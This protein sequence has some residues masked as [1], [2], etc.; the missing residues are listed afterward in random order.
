VQNNHAPTV[1]DI[2]DKTFTTGVMFNSE[3]YH[4]F[5]DDGKLTYTITL[6][7]GSPIPETLAMTKH[8]LLV[9]TISEDISL[10][11]TATDESGSSVSTTLQLN[12]NNAPTVSDIPTINA[13]IDKM[14]MYE[15]NNYFTDD[16][17]LDITATLT[18]DKPL[19]DWVQIH[20][21]SKGHVVLIGTMPKGMQTISVLITGTDTHGIS[22]SVPVDIIPNYAPTT[23]GISDRVVA[24]GNSFISELSE[25]FYDLDGDTMTFTSDNLPDDVF[26]DKKSGAITGI[27]HNNTKDPLVHIIPI[28]AID[29]HGASITT[30]MNIIVKPTP[31][32]PILE[33]EPEP[34]QSPVKSHD[35]LHLE[36]IAGETL[37]FDFNSQIEDP[38][39]DALTFSYYVANSSKNPDWL[40]IDPSTGVLT[41]EVPTTV[42]GFTLNIYVVANDGNGGETRM[43]TEVIGLEG[44][45]APEGS[46]YDITFREGQIFTYDVG[47]QVKD[48][49]G[50]ALTYALI[51]NYGKGLVDDIQGLELADLQNL[52]QNL[53]DWL[54][55]SSDSGILTADF[56][57]YENDKTE[58]YIPFTFTD[59][60]ESLDFS[61]YAWDDVGAG[62]FID[63][64]NVSIY[65]SAVLGDTGIVL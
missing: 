20:T 28:T 30:T 37:A 29:E 48:I 47:S 11:I 51:P 52:I 13:T 39:G 4:Y 49:D 38:D 53:P 22:A 12:S 17:V 40:T 45:Q 43:L 42:H 24:S 44:N 7:N 35:K 26:L 34:N 23:E 57:D 5:N 46:I 18:N 63:N 59:G 62:G 55:F 58:S 41:G 6:A 31:V 9:G 64:F 19:P 16:G 10:I 61:L 60:A 1:S 2:P 50:D 54:Q 65:D 14:F 33:P 27:L 8:G 3:L 25:D 21:D 36:G 15:L 32:I 56:S